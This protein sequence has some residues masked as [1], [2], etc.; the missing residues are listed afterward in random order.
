LY[1]R[2]HGGP[3]ARERLAMGRGRGAVLGSETA[4]PHPT[5]LDRSARPD[6]EVVSRAAVT[7]RV[8]LPD[9]CRDAETRASCLAPDRQLSRVLHPSARVRGTGRGEGVAL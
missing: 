3:L 1:V 6:P 7:H 8:L 2:G 5:I 4:R 9:D